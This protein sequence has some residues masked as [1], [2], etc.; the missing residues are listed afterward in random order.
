MSR[1][2]V[3][4]WIHRRALRSL[5]AYDLKQAY[6]GTIGGV[7][8][9]VL[10]P[11]L[12]IIIFSVI[13][14]YGIR[15]PLGNAPYVFGFAAAYV[16]WIFLSG[17]LTGSASSLVSHRFLIKRVVFPTAVIPASP[18]LVQALPHAILVAL[19][20]VA[21]GLAAYARFPEA[22][23][24]FYFFAC[25]VLLAAS[26]GL[27]LAALTV[28]IRDIPQMLPPALHVWFWLTPVAWSAGQ[29]PARARRL[30]AFNPAS[31]LVTGYRYAL[32]PKIFPSPT[33]F[34][35]AAFWLV[36]AG[37]LLVAVFCFRRLR[38]HFWD[39]L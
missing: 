15:L 37:T 5:A 9:S 36:A 29:L 19:T 31:Y 14:S 22:L 13:F 17:S 26:T 25:T 4:L 39:C 20:G 33:I 2:A 18:I 28:V 24:I 27:L 23:L 30:M 12:P 32:M 16:P 10:T 21:C 11:L 3:S 1:E 38:G 34:E 35:T 7:A 6:A 8:W